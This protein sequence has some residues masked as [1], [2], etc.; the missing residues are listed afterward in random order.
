MKRLNDIVSKFVLAWVLLAGIHV[1]AEPG[2]SES[3][4]RCRR[5]GFVAAGGA[6]A[7]EWT[8]SESG[9]GARR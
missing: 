7:S 3:R 2:S 8:G 9:S 4:L 1:A 5:R 6:I